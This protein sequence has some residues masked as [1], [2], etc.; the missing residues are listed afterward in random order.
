MDLVFPV[1]DLALL[2]HMAVMSK[3]GV[4]QFLENR[5]LKLKAEAYDSSLICIWIRVVGIKTSPVWS[6]ITGRQLVMF[7]GKKLYSP[8]NPSQGRGCTES[9]MARPFILIYLCVTQNLSRSD[10]PPGTTWLSMFLKP[11]SP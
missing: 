8:Y 10:R 1:H 4:S 2:I 9:P 11:A 5:I 7:L 6:E 3:N